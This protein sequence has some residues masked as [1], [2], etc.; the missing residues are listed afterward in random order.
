M[1]S[2]MLISGSPGGFYKKPNTHLTY[3]GTCCRCLLQL[4]LAYHIINIIL[5]HGCPWPSSA[6]EHW[7]L[8]C[9]SFSRPPHDDES[10]GQRPPLDG[11][12][13]GRI[14][15]AKAFGLFPSGQ[16]LTWNNCNTTRARLLLLFILLSQCL[17]SMVPFRATSHPSQEPWPL[18]C[19]SPKVCWDTSTFMWFG[20]VVSS[21]VWSHMWPGSSTTC[22]FNEI[23]IHVGPNTW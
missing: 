4:Q 12:L 13:D 9:F 11:G 22:Y 1:K 18:H 2:M 6:S 23:F 20:N 5:V 19:E 21:V 8:P 7:D 15:P 3:K 14:T 17:I 10:P 16:P